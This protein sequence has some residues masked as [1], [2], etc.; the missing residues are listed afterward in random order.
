MKMERRDL[1]IGTGIVLIV[2]TADGRILERFLDG[3]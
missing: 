3:L 2:T 1:I